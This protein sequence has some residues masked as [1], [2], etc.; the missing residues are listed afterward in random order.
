MTARAMQVKGLR[1]AT[2]I[3]LYW[4]A[5]HFNGETGRCFP[6]IKRLSTLA[7]M[8]ER[9]VRSQIDV[10]QA[11]KLVEIKKSYRPDGQQTSNNY[12]LYLP[13]KKI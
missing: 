13:P 5:D 2:K 4:L 8:S 10:L 11:M 6:S 1:P 12:I 9:S 7:E 3:V